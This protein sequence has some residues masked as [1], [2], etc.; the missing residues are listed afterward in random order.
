MFINLNLKNVVMK[1][2]LIAIVVSSLALAAKAQVSFGPKVGGNLSMATTTATGVKIDPITFGFNAGGFVNDKFAN[3]FAGKVE[4]FYSGESIK[5]KMIGH[6]TVYTNNIG[7]LNIPV[8]F[9]FVTNGGFYLETGPQLGFVLSATNTS[10]SSSASIDIKNDVNST[11]FSWCFGLGFGGRKGLG[12]N[13]RY[14]A[15]LSNVNSTGSGSDKSS[16]LSIGLFYSLQAKGKTTTA[17]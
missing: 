6:P 10:D 17:Q 2:I 14:A 11:K 1:K 16:I 15:G 13:I 9:Q 12:F 8:L 4:L 5:Y 3:Q 7:Y